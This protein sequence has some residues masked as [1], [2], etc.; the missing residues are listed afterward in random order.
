M[1]CARP[2]SHDNTWLAF[3]PA[4][5]TI[6]GLCRWKKRTCY[7]SGGETPITDCFRTALCAVN[8]TK[9]CPFVPIHSPE[10]TANRSNIIHLPAGESGIF[11]K[12]KWAAG[13]CHSSEGT[14]NCNSVDIDSR[15]EK[16]PGV[17][18]Y[19]GC[20]LRVEDLTILQVTSGRQL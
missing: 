4:V 15:S 6:R 5:I 13:Y 9:G 8:S 10:G 20:V 2:H 17:M 1:A 3:E 18:F 16:G 7:Q 14:A 12:K 11:L 19:T